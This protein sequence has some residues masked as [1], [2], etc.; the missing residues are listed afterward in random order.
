MK[1]YDCILVLLLMGLL[2]EPAP[3]GAPTNTFVGSQSCRDC[4][5]GFYQKW[6]TSHHGLAMQPFTEAF[7]KSQ[8][9]PMTN[10]IAVGPDR[11]RADLSKFPVVVREAGPRGEKQYR[12]EHVLGGKNVFYFLAL[13]DKGRLQ[14]LP[15][16]FDVR[17]KE[18]F[19]TSASAMRHFP[20]VTNELVHWT[21]PPYTFNT[22]CHSCHVSQLARNYDPV[23]ETYHTTWKEPGI[24]CETCH[25]PS[26]EHV[27]VCL[28]AGDRKPEDLKII[29]TT[30]MTPA[31]R[32][33]HCSVCHA[34]T[35]ILSDGFP[36]GARLLDHF[37][38]VTFE[39]PDYYPDGR[40]LGENYTYTSWRL[41]PCLKSEQFECLHCHTSSGRFR[42]KDDPNSAC[43]PCHE[44][45]VKNVTTHSHHPPG[46]AGNQCIA[47]HMP[48]TEF[49]RMVRS[50]HSMLP[51]TPAAT[52][53]FQS[54]NAC[55]VCHTNKDA[56]WADKLV[57]EWHKDD[58]QAPVLGRAGLVD[59]ARK[60]QWSSLPDILAYLAG[61]NRNEVF[62]AS[63]IRLLSP[64]TDA[65]KWPSLRLAAADSSPLVRAAALAELQADLGDKSSRDA[66][67]KALD[68]D[69]R[70]VRLAAAST[71]LG[72]PRGQLAASQADRL[73][74]VLKEYLAMLES[75]PDDSLSKYNLG[76]YH[77]LRGD[78]P[79]AIAAYETSAR[80][81][82]AN[83]LPL[84]NV[85]MLYA[86][87]GQLDKAER[88]LRQAL[89]REPS[90]S[91]ANFN[92]GL[93]VA[94]K[95]DLK[96]AQL[97][98]RAA[99]KADPTMAAAAYN[100][101]VIVGA[102]RPDEAI[103]LCRQAA[104]NRPSEPKYAFTLAYYQIQNGDAAGATATLEK[105]L[106]R[107]PSHF[108]SVTM[109][110]QIHE[111][112]GRRKEAAALYESTLNRATLPA[113][114]Q[115]ALRARIDAL[116][117]TGS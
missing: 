115:A 16:A 47:C 1:C 76:N 62:A 73:D 33:D 61:R 52:L 87:A 17:R 89:N 65:S 44:Q 60:A 20:N 30:T 29:R 68:D 31:Q 3:A 38:L 10:E 48:K 23:T 90:N 116:R 92:L 81:D 80:L 78:R 5:Q 113:D 93:L 34:K 42:Q 57:R 91:A 77:Q 71:L 83:I 69:Y 74:R 11:Y 105:V 70:V 67:L 103:A 66:V 50:D 98:L 12:I 19:D 9:L 63:L 54:P 100:L 2:C 94:E 26:A 39:N 46:S 53:R 111:R 86:E 96:E 99:L 22:A 110:G 108:D 85:S 114:A 101:A 55:N 36:P 56:A 21:E 84:V 49:A 88:A 75:R 14:T 41:S 51:P 43:L 25:G 37:G 27:R 109:L 112:A 15:V 117:K 35:M 102:D 13:L 58:Y 6:A 79:A 24:N 8:L 104:Q 32:N 82:S 106:D 64:C 28:A 107:Y 18:W 4:H 97:R 45:R 40:D 95:G 72:Y 59:T 7:A